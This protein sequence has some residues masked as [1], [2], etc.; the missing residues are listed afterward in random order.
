MRGI[1]LSCVIGSE[2]RQTTELLEVIPGLGGSFT[3]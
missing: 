1:I 2:A 3:R